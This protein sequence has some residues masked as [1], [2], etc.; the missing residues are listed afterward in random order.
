MSEEERRTF[1]SDCE[2]VSNALWPLFE[3]NALGLE[4]VMDRDFSE[5]E[6]LAER[7]RIDRFRE[8]FEDEGQFRRFVLT[9]QYSTVR[10]FLMIHSLSMMRNESGAKP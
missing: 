1:H 6:V 4:T 7:D 3:P 10:I 8:S 5:N 2:S 9:E